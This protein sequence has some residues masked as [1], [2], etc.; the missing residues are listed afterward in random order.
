M[1]YDELLERIDEEGEF[2]V[3]YFDCKPRMITA[4][5]R[6]VE[7]HKPADDAC[8]CDCGCCQFCSY[9]KEAYP[10]KTI[11]IIINEQWKGNK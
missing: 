2:Q 1:T 7:L 5:R 3:T 10:C 9:C 8:S 4:L 6:V 11:K